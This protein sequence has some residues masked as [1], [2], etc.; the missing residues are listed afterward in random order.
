MQLK[1]I[2]LFFVIKIQTVHNK[3]SS[4]YILISR[5][6]SIFLSSFVNSIN[7]DGISCTTFFSRFGIAHVLIQ[8]S[9]IESTFWIRNFLKLF[10]ILLG[11]DSI[12]FFHFDTSEPNSRIKLTTIS[13]AKWRRKTEKQIGLRCL[14]IY[15]KAKR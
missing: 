7:E 11:N 8:I 10:L 12:F 15:S 3:Y 6:S 9:S 4:K 5:Y 1:L 2:L 13:F 14:Y